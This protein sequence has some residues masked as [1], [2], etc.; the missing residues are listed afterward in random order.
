MT[1]RLNRQDQEL[2]RIIGEVLHYIWD[3]IGVAG[4]PQARDEYDGYVGP[5]F[6]LLRSGAS[7]ADVSEHLE[8]IV[9]NRMGLPSRKERS[10]EAASTLTDWRDHQAQVAA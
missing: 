8:Q 6:T 9:A 3:P 1:Q 7:D 10:D 5:V 4:V 2:L